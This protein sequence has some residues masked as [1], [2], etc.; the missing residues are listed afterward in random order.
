[1]SDDVILILLVILVAIAFP[2]LAI[3]S[4]VMALGLKRRVRQLEDQVGQLRSQ[5]S[6]VQAT[7]KP[8]TTDTLR[9]SSIPVP[10]ATVPPDAPKATPA[11]ESQP[12]TPV[13]PVLPPKPTMEGEET[14]IP[15]LS[16]P[17]AARQAAPARA[18]ISLEERLGTRWAVWVGGVA[19]ALGGAFLVRYAIEEDLIGPA[20]RIIAGLLFA[21]ALI[22]GGEYLRRRPAA[23]AGIGAAYIPGVVTAAGTVALFATIY[24]AYAVYGF[25]SPAQAFILLGAVGVGTMY[26]AALHGPGLAGLGLVGAYGTPLLVSTSQPSPW[27]LALFVL[28]VTAAAFVLS[29]ARLWRWLA[30]TASV[31][32]LLYGALLINMMGDD[33]SPVAAFTLALALLIGAVLVY[34]PH[35]GK[36]YQSFD[37]VGAG[38][39]A[40]LAVL[41]LAFAD[42]DFFSQTSLA[43]LLIVVAVALASALVFDA[44]APAAVIAG[45]AAVVCLWIWPIDSQ[46]AA[47]PMMLVPG[48]LYLPFLMPDA[49]QAYLEMAIIPAVALFAATTSSLMRQP[50]ALQPAFALALAGAGTPIF[51]LATAYLRIE[52]FRESL[53][54]G[55]VAAGLALLFAFTTERFLRLEARTAPAHAN[56][57]IPGA[58][59][60][61]HAVASC[62]AVALTLAFVIADSPLTLAFG[63]SALGAAWV[64]TLRPLPALRWCAA[65]FVL[66]VLARLGGAWM[67]AGGVLDGFPGWQDIALRY[68]IPAAAIYGGGVWLRR[69]RVDTPAVI[70]DFGAIL[71][72]ATAA[73][74]AIRLTVRGPEEALHP[75]MSLAEAG[76]YSML[77][78]VVATVL[79]YRSA[80][81]S[82]PVYRLAAPVVTIVGLCTTLVGPLVTANPQVSD[83]P[84]AGGILFNELLPGYV[85][86]GLAAA[87]A[88]LAW[89]WYGQG[90]GPHIDKA[91]FRALCGVTA[92]VLGFFYVTLEV[93]K[94][95]T[96]G[97]PGFEALSS[98]ENWGYTIAWLLYGIALLAIG[99]WAK[100]MPIRLASAIVIMLAVIKAFLFDLSELEGIWRALSFIGLGV[101]LIG[102]GLV[103]QR[104]LF[105]KRVAEGKQ[106]I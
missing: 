4:F 78:F 28:V 46:L 2:V 22:A 96:G 36:T 62:S 66:L 80:S 94:I 95:F 91:I 102:I 8:P 10:V 73:V 31:A 71:L 48:H 19:L 92:F 37:W 21:L 25:L 32:A 67:L 12:V 52:S 93:R 42:A 105:G 20:A 68:A 84:V 104:L 23:P 98:P 34:E 13:P 49:L 106:G 76:L 70:L 45:I 65:G 72:A 61:L 99:I 86:P 14:D 63:L 87:G 30:V 17:I 27:A 81:T 82:S 35:R 101:A 55:A 83:M 89:R 5:H 59:S 69:S 54:F 3:A 1:M 64:S 40:G 60:S 77:A 50:R 16:P 53:P 29:R 79:V 90:V 51:A 75:G 18:S 26:A 44:M 15:A 33:P 38:A 103:Y 58:G 74:L 57:A 43:T 100:A 11:P 47:E 56:V 9:E 85:L 97:L 88:A 24:A 41:A 6:A 7:A 39:L